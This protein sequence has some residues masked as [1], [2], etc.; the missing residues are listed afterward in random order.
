MV[1]WQDNL[2]DYTPTTKTQTA[3]CNHSTLDF[4][5]GL[6]ETIGFRS[7][8]STGNRDKYHRQLALC[9]SCGVKDWCLQTALDEKYEFGIWGG[10][11]PRERRTM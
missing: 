9:E 2:T 5:G 4:I 1:E 11:F 3:A 6:G 8:Q 10:T 7:G